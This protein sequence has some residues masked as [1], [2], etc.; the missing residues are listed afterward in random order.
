MAFD[1]S[2]L[3]EDQRNEI[4]AQSEVVSMAWGFLESFYGGDFASAWEK[5][6]PV[7]RLCLAQWWTHANKD[8][9]QAFGYDL[10]TTAEELTLR[11]PGEHLLWD[12]FAGVV[13]RDFRKAYPLDVATAGIGSAPR[14]MAL[15]TELLYVHRVLPE[16]GLWQPDER[17]EVYSLLMKFETSK[18]TVLNWASDRTPTPGYPPSL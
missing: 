7:F 2:E 14:P 6:N 9:L 8:K 3:P 15:D 17:R 12:Q 5:A 13:L 11:P 1:P 16:G 10:V 4:L 18:W